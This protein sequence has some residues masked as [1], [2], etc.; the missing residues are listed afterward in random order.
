MPRLNVVFFFSGKDVNLVIALLVEE[1]AA[2]TEEATTS[3][4]VL[5]VV[6]C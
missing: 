4:A 6:Q 3:Q 5:S 2:V 1:V